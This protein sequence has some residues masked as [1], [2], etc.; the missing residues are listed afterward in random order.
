[1]NSNMTLS[2]IKSILRRE[3]PHLAQEYG[4]SGVSVFGSYVRDEQR[5]DSDLD[6]LVDL[7][8]PSC[9]TLIGLV[10]LEDYLTSQLGVQ[11]DIAVKSNLRKRIGR[12]ILDEAVP[13]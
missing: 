12:R 5:P 9:I 8:R 11:V 13:V 7:E 2:E 3:K 10:Q 6:V 4:V 1:M